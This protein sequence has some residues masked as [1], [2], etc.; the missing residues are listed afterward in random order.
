[1]L[2][3]FLLLL[4]TACVNDSKTFTFSG[5]STNWIANLKVTQT[6]DDYETQDFVLEYKGDDVN[7]VGEI[8]YSVVSVGSFSRSGATLEENGTLIDSD[9]AN[10]T[11]AK[12]TEN[13]E[14]EVTVEWN[15]NT[16]KFKLDMQLVVDVK[17]KE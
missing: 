7:S 10:P 9:K 5:N 15:G 1:V 14:V 11:N 3:A 6:S 8:S 12:V 17:Q 13:T 4:L 16:E 2:L